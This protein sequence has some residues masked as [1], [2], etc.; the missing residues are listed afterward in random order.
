MCRSTPSWPIDAVGALVEHL[1][2]ETVQD[3]DHRGQR[4]RGAGA[5]DREP[6]VAQGSGH[7]RLRQRHRDPDS[8][9]VSRFRMSATASRASR[10]LLV[11][12]GERAGV[13]RSQFAGAFLPD[14]GDEGLD[15]DGRSQDRTASASSRSSASSSTS[16]IGVRVRHVHDDVQPG[17]H[18]LGEQ[19]GVIH[20]RAAVGLAQ[21]AL[22]PLPNRRCCSGHG[23]GTPVPTRSGRTGRA[24]ANSRVCRR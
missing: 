11:R 21:R 19:R 1:H 13:L 20:G 5:V 15:A 23:A 18:R 14:P 16:G 4:H 3:R 10:V 8:P 2:P 6:S 7:G 24:R 12:L 9:R 17:E 22:D